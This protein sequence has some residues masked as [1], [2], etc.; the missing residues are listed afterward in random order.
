MPEPTTP[1][2]PAAHAEP[3]SIPPAI[4]RSIQQLQ[5]A[6]DRVHAGEQDGL[7]DE[8]RT[9][10]E[11]LVMSLLAV[12][13]MT[14]TH[15]T[16]NDAFE[17]PVRDL[18]ATVSDL[19]E[20]L[21]AVHVVLVEDQVYVNDTRVRFD[22]R[23]ELGR[24]LTFELG[25]HAV[26][27]LSFHDRLTGIEVR[28]LVDL[29]GQPPAEVA[30]RQA[31]ADA[32]RARGV[33]SIELHGEYRFKLS[34]ETEAHASTH[35]TIHLDH[36]TTAVIDHCWDNLGQNR[37]PPASQ[38]R[39]V[40]AELVQEGDYTALIHEDRPGIGSYTAHVQRVTHVALMLGQALGLSTEVLQD[41]GVAAMFHDIGYA[42]REGQQ[43]D[44]S[45]KVVAEGFA[46]P[47]P[48]HGSAGVRLMLKQRG[49]HEGKIRRALATIEHHRDLDNAKGRPSLFGRILRISEDYDNLIRV[50]GGGFPPADALARMGAWA[51]L[52]YDAV[53]LQLLIN[54]L[55][56]YPPGTVLELQDGR[57]VRSRSTV[58]FPGS[59]E[60][61]LCEVLREANGRPPDQETIIDLDREGEVLRVLRAVR[62][63]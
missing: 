39:R 12:L 62:E 35:D 30:P 1:V 8:V 38:V 37:M 48:R 19:H 41:L 7:V 32:M 26:G 2:P 63:T 36:R 27:G 4:L 50:R 14:R 58:R 22:E 16:G 29:L 18:R 56:R 52:R 28:T 24:K 46:P 47:F 45:G 10:G 33:R 57:I 60:K 31:L 21:G 3:A 44:E 54:T 6:R 55:G 15:G 53:L 34:G 61:P 42:S 11:H 25:R 17:R 51:G 40:V 13:R 59:W 23:T 9:R 5:R 20:R 49:F 43:V